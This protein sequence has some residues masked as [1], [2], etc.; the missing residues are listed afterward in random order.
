MNLV[1]VVD[2]NNQPLSN[3]VVE[4]TIPNNNTWWATTY[5]FTDSTGTV[6]GLVPANLELEMNV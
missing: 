6:S 5:G 1:P 3:T 4:L 2:Q